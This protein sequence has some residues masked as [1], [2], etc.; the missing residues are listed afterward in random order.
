[1]Q[2]ARCGGEL[3]LGERFCGDCGAPVVAPTPTAVS[4]TPPPTVAA[5]PP[6]RPA[7]GANGCLWFSAGCV[8]GMGLTLLILIMLV[9]YGLSSGVI[10]VFTLPP[11]P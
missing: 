10:P 6:A 1:M 2:C 3:T 5:F 4:A 11:V 7:R 8:S 9:A